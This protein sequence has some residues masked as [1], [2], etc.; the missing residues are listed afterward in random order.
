[1]SELINKIKSVVSKS[2]GPKISFEKKGIRPKNDWSKIL[3]G[4][5]AVVTILAGMSVYF[6]MGVTR[7]TFFGAEKGED[8]MEV[9]INNKLLKKIVEDINFREKNLIEIRNN[10]SFPADPS[11]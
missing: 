3:F 1:M 5:I 9:K 4:T 6:Y 7:G 2:A 11:L 10:K 8:L